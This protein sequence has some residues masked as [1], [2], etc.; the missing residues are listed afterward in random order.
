MFSIRFLPEDRTYQ[1]GQPTDLMLAA[2]AC[3]IWVEQPCGSKTICGKCKVRVADGNASLSA[4]D[5]RLL[6]KEE[7]RDGWRLGC[8]LNLSSASVIEI[9]PATRSVAVKPFGPPDLFALG[10]RPNIVKRY[11]ELKPPDEDNQYASFDIISRALGCPRLRAE[12]AVVQ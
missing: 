5:E 2:A 6:T 8:Q 10:F 11:L 4:A 7:L 9:P 3:D 12:M 1:A